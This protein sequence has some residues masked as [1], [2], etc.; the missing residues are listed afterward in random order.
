VRMQEKWLIAGTFVA[1][2]AIFYGVLLLGINALLAPLPLAAGAT[3][4][5]VFLFRHKAK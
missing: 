3:Y 4:L 5:F 2:L 1:F